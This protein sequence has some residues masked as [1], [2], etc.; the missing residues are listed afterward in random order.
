MKLNNH[1]YLIE[2][3]SDLEIKN[4][5]GFISKVLDIDNTPNT[6]SNFLH[7][8]SNQLS[9][10]EAENIIKFNSQKSFGVS[11]GNK[12]I[13]IEINGAGHQAQNAL[14]KTLEEPSSDTYF[15]ITIPSSS[16]LLPTVQSRVETYSVHDFFNKFDI[17][18]VSN[19]IESIDV[20]NFL[21]STYAERLEFIKNLI[22]E[23]GKEGEDDS[24]RLFIF[25]NEIE[26]TLKKDELG[27][28]LDK[29]ELIAVTNVRE[30]FTDNGAS[31]KMLFEYLA[32]R[33]PII[34]KF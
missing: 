4:I 15:L 2:N 33:L 21:K 12:V 14:L 7:I 28:S 34:K 8:K 23:T 18:E 3:V 25:L 10:E 30:Y 32:L 6:S 19:E 20:K 31:K 29:D 1:A 17:R 13:L 11:G 9:V 22:N 24:S 16:L 27:R 5:L 26:K